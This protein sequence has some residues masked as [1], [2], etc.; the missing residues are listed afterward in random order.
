MSDIN[1]I[2]VRK[3][4]DL[5]KHVAWLAALERPRTNIGA[6]VYHNA[7]QSIPN[8]TLTALAFNSE[9][10]DT[11]GLHDT[12]TNNSRLTCTRAGIYLITG[13]LAYGTAAAGVRQS[14]IR[15]NGSTLL[16]AVNA[17][18]TAG[19]TVAAVHNPTTLYQ[20]AVGDYVELV[21]YQDTGGAL[22]VNVFAN[23]SPRVR[24]D[25]GVGGT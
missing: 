8:T 22:N 12:V 24:A 17:G 7:A 18:V 5:E 4:T 23:F 3:I 20:L 19:T 15:L 1:T 11:D 2:F 25:A 21:A 9:R 6:R 16:V 14:Y 10:Y 13:S